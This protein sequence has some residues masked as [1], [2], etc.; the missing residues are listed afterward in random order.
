MGK[1]YNIRHYEHY[2]KQI[3]FEWF[4]NNSSNTIK[5]LKR[6]KKLIKKLDIF[7][8]GQEQ[9]KIENIESKEFTSRRGLKTIEVPQQISKTK[10]PIEHS[11]FFFYKGVKTYERKHTLLNQVCVG[12][13]YFSA[14]EIILYDRKEKKIQKVIEYKSIRKVKLKNFAVVIILKSKK[15]VYLRY[16]DN[17]IIY[18]SLKRSSLEFVDSFSDELQNERDISEKTIEFLLNI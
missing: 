1:H 7:L 4:A 11:A 13:I 5:F 15:K 18:L 17:E 8:T 9:E 16:K 12:E 6:T 14:K 10:L 2:K 3:F